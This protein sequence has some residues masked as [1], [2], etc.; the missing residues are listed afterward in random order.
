MLYL[1]NNI[2]TVDHNYKEY[3]CIFVHKKILAFQHR[4]ISLKEIIND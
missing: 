2:S 1:T 3:S 4:I